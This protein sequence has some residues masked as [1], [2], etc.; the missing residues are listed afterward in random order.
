MT[1]VRF[2]PS[3]TGPLHIGGM[4]TALYNYLFA[5]Q[6]GGVFILRSED[7]DR[8]RFVEGAEDYIHN[9]LSWAGMQIDEGPKHGGEYGP[10][11][12]SERLAIYKK[13]AQELI[14]SGKAY[15]A[16]DSVEQLDEQRALAKAK[17]Q[18]T[19]QYGSANRMSLKNSLSLPKQKVDELLNEGQP[20]VI[21]IAIPENEEVQF[22]DIIRGDISFQ[23]NVLDDKVLMKADGYPTY[24]FANV[25]DDH[26]MEITHVIRGE[27]WLSSTPLHV[28]LYN[29]FGWSSPQFAH[30]PLILKPS[31]QGKLSKRDGA[32]FGF[33]VFPM[34]WTD[35]DSTELWPGYAEKGFLPSAFNNYMAFLGWNPGT[36]KEEYSLDE[37]VRDFDL[38]KVSK[39][40]ARFD[41]EKAMWFNAQQL[42]KLPISTYQEQIKSHLKTQG[43][44]V[45]EAQALQI[46]TMYQSRLRLIPEITE[47]ADYLFGSIVSWDDKMIR[48]KWKPENKPAF[49][50][51]LS[52]FKTLSAEDFSSENCESLTKAM[53]AENQLGFGQV[54]P[55]LRLAVCGTMQGPSI[56]D[57]MSYLGQ[58]SVC[59]RLARA[60]ENFDQF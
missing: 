13:Y 7:T 58:S 51:L 24:H 26:L 50:D 1:R 20:Y 43:I 37:L 39:A 44:D 59:E 33:P 2:A 35:K 42:Q 53:M 48:K 22:T 34:N 8:N 9:S 3:P 10:Y 57:V 54:L 31:G 60:I 45:T 40:G 14:D 15:Y 16:F 21:R 6:K 30:L 19:W 11:R 23:S 17:G 12:Q 32:K 28:L 55:V 36:E 5:K 49:Q 56:F 52:K 4:R 29:A 41:Y 27:E 47:Q 38:N 18:H 25:V 46:S